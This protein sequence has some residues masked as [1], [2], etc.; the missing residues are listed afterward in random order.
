MKNESTLKEMNM[1]QNGLFLMCILTAGWIVTSYSGSGVVNAAVVRLEDL[2]A[3][4]RNMELQIKD[5][6]IEY[7]WACGELRKGSEEERILTKE[8]AQGRIIKVVGPSRVAL[9]LSRSRPAKDP[10]DP[11]YLVFDLFRYETRETLASHDQRTWESHHMKAWDGQVSY[12]YSSSSTWPF[13]EGTISKRGKPNSPVLSASP[14]SFSVYWGPL[15]GIFEQMAL[16]VVLKELG[17][18]DPNVYDINGFK[19]VKVDLWNVYH[20]RIIARAYF[21]IEHNYAPVRFEYIS[22]KG[23]DGPHRVV[24]AVDILS[25]EEVLPGLWFPTSGLVSSPTGSAPWNKYIC[26]GKIL[27]NQGLTQKDFVVKFPPGTRVRDE[28]KGT[29]YIAK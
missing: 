21:D 6:A 4:C 8:F 17:T 5:I 26:K 2:V 11:N 28:V 1:C 15:S 23:Q 20:S 27:I 19:A 16:S 7:E 24:T 25:L 10:N 29:R 14:L 22:S 3:A 12:D 13:P 9:T 18:L